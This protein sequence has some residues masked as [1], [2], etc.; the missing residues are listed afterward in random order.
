MSLGL[1]TKGLNKREE[2]PKNNTEKIMNLPPN[3][4]SLPCALPLH[5]LRFSLLANN[6]NK[7]A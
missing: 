7:F 2:R 4:A 1:F 5:L 6:L 3:V